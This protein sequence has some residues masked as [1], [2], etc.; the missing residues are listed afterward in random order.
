M[1]V[2]IKLVGTGQVKQM[3]K[4]YADVF[5]KMKRAV[6]F[7]DLPKAVVKVEKPIRVPRTKK[8]APVDIEVVEK[9]ITITDETA[10]I[11]T[12]KEETTE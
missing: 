2:K 7:V 4:R 8:K 11:E 9:D 3:E 6:Y 1:K 12:E 5:V 10:I